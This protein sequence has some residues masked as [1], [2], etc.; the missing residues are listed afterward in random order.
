MGVL[1]TIAP[2]D[3]ELRS[4]LVSEGFV[5]LP[6]VHGRWPT[7]R[8]VRDALARLPGIQVTWDPAATPP[9]ADLATADGQW[10]ALRLTHHTSDETPCQLYF[11]KGSQ[12]L[13]TSAILQ[14]AEVTGPLVIYPDTGSDIQVVF[15]GQVAAD[16]SEQSRSD[17]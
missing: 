13:I 14:L 17:A 3:E 4:W 1:Y 6:S 5:G 12:D 10:T 16:P 9:E 7:P 2:L 8:E 15:G 11:S